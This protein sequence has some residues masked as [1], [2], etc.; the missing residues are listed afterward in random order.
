MSRRWPGPSPTATDAAPARSIATAAPAT[1]IGLVLMHEPF[2]YSTRFGLSS[3]RLP[4]TSTR[5][6]SRPREITSAKSTR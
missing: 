2:S 1:T 3:T 6:V 5:S 4:R